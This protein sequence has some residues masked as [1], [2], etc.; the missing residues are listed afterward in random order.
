MLAR[1]GEA[2]SAGAERRMGIPG[3]IRLFSAELLA[4]FAAVVLGILASLAINS[5]IQGGPL[6]PK[7][8]CEAQM[9]QAKPQN[10]VTAM[11]ELHPQ[12]VP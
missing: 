1:A 6:L 5:C 12:R 7:L 3:F 4:T 2:G 8:G 10:Q 11:G 9:S